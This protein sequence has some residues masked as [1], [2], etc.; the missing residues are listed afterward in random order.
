MSI[1]SQNAPKL[2]RRRQA[3][4]YLTDKRFCESVES[5]R[6]KYNPA[7][8]RLIRSHVTLCREDEVNDWNELATR[9]TNLDQISV[10]ICFGELVREDNLVYLPALGS[11]SS[12]NELRHSLLATED[13]KP[14][15]HQPHLTLIHPRNGKCTDEVFS[16]IQQ[17]YK[18]FATE[19]NCVT[20]IEQAGNEPWRDLAEYS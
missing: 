4:L 7:Q 5:I 17:L 20:F 15:L 3:T 10:T 12:F 18:P 14:R 1:E 9:L 13:I 11:S 16:S 2:L 19:F 6:S 8:F